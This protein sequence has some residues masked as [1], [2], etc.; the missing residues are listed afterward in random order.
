VTGG[1]LRTSELS[2]LAA[3]EAQA[4]GRRR[5]VAVIDDSGSVTFG[6][7]VDAVHRASAWLASRGVEPG[8]RVVTCLEPSIPHLVLVLG[9]MHRGAIAAPA[10]IRLTRPELDRYLAPIEPTLVIADPSL[11]QLVSDRQPLVLRATDATGTVEDRLPEI[12]CHVP[13]ARSSPG[14]G[15]P[16]IVFGTGGTT[17]LPK[18]ATFSHRA[19]WL[20]AAGVVAHQRVRGTDVDLSATPFFHA[21][22]ITG[23]LST[24]FCGGSVRLLRRFE[25]DRALHA[26]DEVGA[27]RTTAPPTVLL[28][29]AD[30]LAAAGRTASLRTALFST[31]EPPPGLSERLRVAF[32]EI[33]LMT[34]YGAT[35]YGPATRLYLDEVPT[36]ERGCIGRAIPGADVGIRRPDGSAADVGEQGELVVRTPWQMTGYWGG[37]DGGLRVGAGNAIHSGD[38]GTVD[39]AGT[40]FLRGRSKELIS[41]GGENVFPGEVEAI[42]GRHPA[43][44]EAAVY[45]A[46]DPYWGERVEAA[47]VLQPGASL[48]LDELRAFARPFLAGFK[49]PKVLRIR[50]SLPRTPNLKVSRAALRAESNGEP[51]PRPTEDET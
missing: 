31:S 45:G 5:A 9:A 25:P 27:T 16:A 7:L 49:L 18:A 43:V 28:A 38:L 12:V 2:Y 21:V 30:T 51:L 6:G 42:L 50:E 37:T 4:R 11:E 13:E 44:A 8:D 19:V 33:E 34:G 10:N 47:V 36:F 35:E 1:R 14:E 26:I 20:W 23:P 46:A 17:G 22:L 32:P 41:T 3:L 40:F 48:E 39:D 15:A 29:M 24:L